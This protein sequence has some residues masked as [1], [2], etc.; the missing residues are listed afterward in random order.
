MTGVFT[1]TP[2]DVPDVPDA[3]AHT[4]T[5]TRYEL[6]V[7]ATSGDPSWVAAVDTGIGLTDLSVTT[8]TASG[9]GALAYDNSSGA[10]TFT[11]AVPGS[12]V[13]DAPAH[14][15]G[16]VR[17][18]LQVPATSGSP[19]WVSAVD[20]TGSNVPDQPSTPA[21]T[22][23]YELQ[24][25]NTGAGSWVAA[26][27]AGISLTDLSVG[28]EAA[29][30]GNGGITYNNT[31][32]VFTYAPP[33][34]TGIATAGTDYLASL[35]TD[36]SD[37]PAGVQN[38]NATASVPR[39]ATAPASPTA[40][41]LWYYTGGE[42]GNEN[43]Q[44]GLYIYHND[45]TTS[46]WISTDG[47]DT[48][49]AT[50]SGDGGGGG[51]GGFTPST[52]GTFITSSVI[53]LSTSSISSQALTLAAGNTATTF[54]ITGGL[55]YATESTTGGPQQVRLINP[56]GIMDGELN[57]YSGGRD[58]N[59]VL[60]PH[61]FGMLWDNANNG[62]RGF[63]LTTNFTGN[64]DNTFQALGENG[65]SFTPSGGVPIYAFTTVVN[66]SMNNINVGLSHSG[67]IHGTITV[68]A[69]ETVILG[70]DNSTANGLRSRL[71]AVQLS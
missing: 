23:R 62:F 34:L 70:I 71:F 31:S 20:T 53:T 44:P 25:T 36:V 67:N 61:S 49:Q 64:A 42:S 10:F 28:T 51:G 15:S 69:N 55:E 16:A 45:G 43:E 57:I 19:T 1:H 41:D 32:G 68:A 11:P 65:T 17:Y 63:P 59:E 6:N 56:A 14:T 58:M 66:G 21:S 40:G 13:P 7:P 26:T 2:A 54:R 30:S 38:S 24:V 33:T 4:S 12:N 47:G 18:E 60:R 52:A 3:P 35:P 5:A 39:S 48:G 22:T 8:G 50:S 46:A 27:E 29:A 9:G 37:Y